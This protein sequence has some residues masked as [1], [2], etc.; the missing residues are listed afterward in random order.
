MRRLVL[1]VALVLLPTVALAECGWVLWVQYR[2]GP[3]RAISEFARLLD[4]Q[5]E[6]GVYWMPTG[7]EPG[8]RSFREK[9]KWTECW[10]REMDPRRPVTK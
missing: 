8:A 7:E 4:C 10:P 9:V 5:M 3:L 2:N 1:I 6:Q